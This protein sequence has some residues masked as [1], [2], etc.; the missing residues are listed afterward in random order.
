VRTLSCGLCALL[1]AG[2]GY[3]VGF[4]VPAHIKT[5]SVNTF[6]NRT[7][8]RNLDF[9]F[10]EALIHEILAKTPLAVAPP[11]K[12]DLEISGEIE[13]L[14]RRVLLSERVVEKGE[15]IDKKDEHVGPITMRRYYLLVNVEMFDQRKNVVFF[16]GKRIARDVDY[17]LNLGQLA[18]LAREQLIRDL[19]RRVVSLAFERWSEK[20]PEAPPS[21]R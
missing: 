21:G 15:G 9:E 7:L 12:A 17:S 5:F 11:G 1:L 13:D 6:R 8:E 20:G 16:E 2:C 10:T 3:R 18:P 19:A 14:A 4:P